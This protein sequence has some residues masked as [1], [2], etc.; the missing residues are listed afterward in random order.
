[1]MLDGKPLPLRVRS[2]VGLVPLIACEVVT[3]EA[4]AKLPR[5]RKRVDWF[6]KNRHDLA[7]G[8][9]YFERDP[10]NGR[11]LLAI[12][13][14]ERL[15]RVLARVFDE[16]EFLSPHGLRSLSKAH[17][18]APFALRIAGEDFRAE[19]EP[20]ETKHRIFGGNSN[21]R[22][23]VW[24]PLN[25]LICE[26]LRRYHHFYGP[27]FTVEI[28]K[29]SGVRMDLREASYELERRLASLFLPD[30]DGHRPCY[31]GDARYARDP[32][33][34]D[35]VLF[36]EYFH[37]DTGKG[38]GASHQTGWTALVARCIEDLAADR[39]P[40]RARG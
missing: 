34:R 29:G 2:M 37:G 5:M 17:G 18:T 23:P 7:E 20:G 28:G 38:L 27:G 21:W 40:S 14:R 8:I 11:G 31:G 6:L 10:R 12:P 3:E 4:V 39:V 16:D 33:W 24:F 25:Y 15:Q 22:G 26:A 9:S 1:M 30:Q 35:L 13:S 36:H 32:A 19:Y